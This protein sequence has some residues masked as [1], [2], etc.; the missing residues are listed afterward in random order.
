MTAWRVALAA[1]A[2]C[3]LAGPALAQEQHR[4]WLLQ[5][6]QIEQQGHQLGAAAESSGS[7]EPNLSLPTHATA[8][9]L[10]LARIRPPPPKPLRCPRKPPSPPPPPRPR[11]PSPPRPP[12]PPPP[13]VSCLP[14]PLWQ[15]VKQ[16]LLL[17]AS[18]ASSTDGSYA[19]APKEVQ[20]FPSDSAFMPNNVLTLPPG[21]GLVYSPDQPIWGLGGSLNRTCVWWWSNVREF[22]K[23]ANK[24]FFWGARSIVPSLATTKWASMLFMLS[25]VA[26]PAF[27][28]DS[29]AGWD[30]FWNDASTQ[31]CALV[32]PEM[33]LA[34]KGVKDG[35]NL[36]CKDAAGTTFVNN[37]KF[38]VGFA[39]DAASASQAV[40]RWASLM[41][42]LGP[43]FLTPPPAAQAPS[44]P[45]P[46]PSPPPPAPSPPPPAPS[47]PPPI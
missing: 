17:F 31:F 22:A 26:P 6:Q 14:D 39:I 12:P 37:A 16:R 18:Y 38:M 30:A 5:R 21:Q 7:E 29:R 28:F 8:Q 23:P 36:P 10:L 20:A 9:R 19:F 42:M 41:W 13:P 27:S 25:N 3:L 1:L 45:P 15:A 33:A 32:I 2:C 43:E 24:A 44:P 4:R 46:E 11:P 47:P 34:R 35:L 40:P